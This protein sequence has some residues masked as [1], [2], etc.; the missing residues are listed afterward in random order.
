MTKPVSIFVFDQPRTAS[1]RARC[2]RCVPIREADFNHLTEMAPKKENG[3]FVPILFL[4]YVLIHISR[5]FNVLS[6]QRTFST[7]LSTKMDTDDIN[8]YYG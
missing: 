1:R 5:V 4:L 3:E 7:I 8:C 6:Q 2:I